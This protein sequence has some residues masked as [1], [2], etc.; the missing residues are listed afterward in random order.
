M[1]LVGHSRSFGDVSLMSGLSEYGDGWAIYEYT[2][3]PAKLA[4]TL[5]PL[6]TRGDA[7]IDI[8]G[9]RVRVRDITGF[10]LI[11]RYLLF[12]DA[13]EDEACG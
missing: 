3:W 8:D 7:K 5:S 11:S 12:L 13:Q 9:S 4:A 10:P 2:A 6:V 1:A